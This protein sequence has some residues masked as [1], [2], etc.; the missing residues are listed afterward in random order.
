MSAMSG[1]PRSHRAREFKVFY[2]GPVS[3]TNSLGSGTMRPL[4]WSDVAD[5]IAFVSNAGE[6]VR[7]PSQRCRRGLL[8]AVYP[9]SAFHN[10]GRVASR[11][12]RILLRRTVQG[13]PS[14]YGAAAGPKP[15]PRPCPARKAPTGRLPRAPLSFEGLVLDNDRPLPACAMR[16]FSSTRRWMSVMPAHAAPR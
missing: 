5:I 15:L 13:L 6:T 12:K 4:P 8:V 14:C 10:C 16:P 11:A 7:N 2:T 1:N 9:E 3:R